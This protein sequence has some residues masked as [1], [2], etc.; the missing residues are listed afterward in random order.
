MPVSPLWAVLF[1]IMLFCLGLSS[2]F[3][4]IEG[5]LVPLQDLNVFPKTWPK[6]AVTGNS[7]IC[8]LFFTLTRISVVYFMVVYFI[9]SL[10]FLRCNMH[11][12][13]SGGFDIH[14]GLW[15]LLAF[16]LRHLWRIHPSASCCIL[17]DGL[18]GVHIWDRQVILK[19]KFTCVSYIIMSLKIICLI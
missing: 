5:I 2:M 14:P 12:L 11:P 6:E 1:F 3:G 10:L 17:R 8:S 16:T 13:L 4:N 19:Y 9:N 15:K 7:H 18:S